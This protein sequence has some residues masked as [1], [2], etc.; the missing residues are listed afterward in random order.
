MA[1]ILPT[2]SPNYVDFK[3]P[4]Q[5]TNPELSSKD[6]FYSPDNKDFVFKDG[7]VNTTVNIDFWSLDCSYFNNKFFTTI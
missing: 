2:Y 5:I 7:E 3:I 6:Y 1:L 4:D